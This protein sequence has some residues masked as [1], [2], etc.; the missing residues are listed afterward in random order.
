MK[1]E[2]A[3]LKFTQ[4]LNKELKIEKGKQHDEQ[5]IAFLLGEI[6]A[7]NGLS[8][9]GKVIRYIDWLSVLLLQ[10]SQLLLLF[11]YFYSSIYAYSSKTTS[12]YNFISIT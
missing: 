11:Y 3:T 8:E 4:N 9:V 1:T 7:I 12:K 5:R 2:K 6:N 10:L